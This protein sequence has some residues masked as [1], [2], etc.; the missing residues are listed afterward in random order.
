MSSQAQWLDAASKARVQAAIAE[1]ERR[2][3]AEFVVTLRLTSGRYWAA[4]LLFGALV[5]FAGLCVYVYHP[6]QF[7]DDLVPPALALMFALSSVLASR[8]GFLQRLLTPR[9]VR[10]ANV[11]RAAFEAFHEQG[12]SATRD[13]TGVLIFISLREQMV[14]VVTDVGVDVGALGNDGRRSL[15]G[16][17]AAVRQ[18]GVDAVTQGLARLGDALATTL[19]RRED[20]INEL[21]D[22]VT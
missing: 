15:A 20:D 5:A 1:A 13:R 11:R 14:E 16:L 7:T 4:S 21:P 12:I 2:T 22:E 18:G 10:E 9:R 8:L 19:P 6:A 3:S 17:K